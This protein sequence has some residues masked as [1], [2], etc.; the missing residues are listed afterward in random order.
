VYRVLEGSRRKCGL[1]CVSCVGRE[2]TEM[3]LVVC[4][5]CWKGAEGYVACG[6]YR[7]L[8]GSRRKCGPIYLTDMLPGNTQESDS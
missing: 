2:Q 6:V 8:E 1:L 7:V 4:I 3:W 5:V